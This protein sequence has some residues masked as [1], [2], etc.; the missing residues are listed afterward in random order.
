MDHLD[1][2][3]YHAYSGVIGITDRLNAYCMKY[4]KDCWNDE[5]GITSTPWIVTIPHEEFYGGGYP[6]PGL[7]TKDYTNARMVQA[8]TQ[9]LFQTL[10]G[11][12][13]KYFLYDMRNSGGM[14]NYIQRKNHYNLDMTPNPMMIAYAGIA[15]LLDGATEVS[16]VLSDVGTNVYAFSWLD[17]DNYPWVVL[18]TDDVVDPGTRFQTATPASST[19][20]VYDVWGN[21]ILSGVST[22]PI[23]PMPVL[24]KGIKFQGDKASMRKAF[25][26]TG[27]ARYVQRKDTVAPNVI[28]T[29]CPKGQLI[30]G[31]TVRFR[32]DAQDT[33]STVISAVG[34]TD[35]IQYSWRLGEMAWSAWSE[36]NFT[37]YVVTSGG[38]YELQVRAK[39]EAG[40]IVN[41]RYRNGV[42]WPSPVPETRK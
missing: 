21:R 10:K 33:D 36:K 40:N 3:S 4:S 18:F 15:S 14:Q 12:T 29:N 35:R 31:E 2:V 39:D 7:Q 24:I 13:S 11:R 32:F 41:S 23:G 19:Y 16:E 34:K 17:S 25:Q 30:R 8:E 38:D 37:D 27:G 6:G 26:T 1:V 20:D 28:V 42:K 9:N 22:I 5:T